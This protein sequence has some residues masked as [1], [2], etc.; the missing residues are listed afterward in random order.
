MKWYKDFFNRFFQIK[1][2]NSRPSFSYNQK[3]T[4][5]VFNVCFCLVEL[6]ASS[7]RSLTNSA[8]LTNAACRECVDLRRDICGSLERNKSY[9][10]TTLLDTLWIIVF[11]AMRSR[12]F[13]FTSH[14]LYLS[15]PSFFF[16]FSYKFHQFSY[17]FWIIVVL[18]PSWRNKWNQTDATWKWNIRTTEGSGGSKQT[19][20]LEQLLNIKKYKISNKLCNIK[21]S[22][23]DLESVY[24]YRSCFLPRGRK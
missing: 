21:H 6:K 9:K 8:K 24:F 5:R 22:I 18:R 10:H 11:T 2:R 15:F 4:W 20:E 19:S 12:C 1:D 23:T 13:D 7:S 16:W 3:L 14:T 17:L